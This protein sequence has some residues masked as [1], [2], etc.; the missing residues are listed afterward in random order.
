MSVPRLM[1]AN[2]AS[3]SPWMLSGVL[4]PYRHRA[5]RAMRI[6]IALP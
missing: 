3:G 4:H 6:N 5:Y 1:G 2:R